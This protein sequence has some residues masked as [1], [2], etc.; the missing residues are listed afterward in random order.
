ML[1]RYQSRILFAG[2]LSLLVLNGAMTAYAQEAQQTQEKQTPEHLVKIYRVKH[3]DASGLM[4]TIAR[5][6]EHSD[7][8]KTVR[9]AVDHNTKSLIVSGDEKT[10][11]LVGSLLQSLDVEPKNLEPNEPAARDV[12]IR[13]VW[14]VDEKLVEGDATA[15]PPDLIPTVEKLSTKFGLGKLVTAGQIIINQHVTQQTQFDGSGTA[16]IQGK[17]EFKVRGTSRFKDDQV[18]ELEV[19]VQTTSLSIERSPVVQQMGAS[20]KATCELAS[21]ISAPIGRPVF[22]GM[23]PIESKTS[24]FVVQVLDANSVADE[25]ARSE[26]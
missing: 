5:I 17:S 23:A 1:N 26:K 6:V 21:K 3:Q 15:I 7:T 2:L 12:M 20:R 25:T 10:Q 16:A 13:I 24:L 18:A 14:L 11:K 19:H 22:F 8:S 4:S 9:I